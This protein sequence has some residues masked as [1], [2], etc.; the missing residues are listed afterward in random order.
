[1]RWTDDEELPAYPPAWLV[2][3]RSALAAIER[4]TRLRQYQRDTWILA[5]ARRIERERRRAGFDQEGRGR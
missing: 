1:V 4:E 2:H 3:F 5:E